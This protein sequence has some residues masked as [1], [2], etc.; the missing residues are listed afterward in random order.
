MPLS[1]KV[2]D[3]Q[4]RLAALGASVAD[5]RR[6]ENIAQLSQREG[7]AETSYSSIAT[8]AEQIESE[9]GELQADLANIRE[10]VNSPEIMADIRK[11]ADI[12]VA[13]LDH[14]KTLEEQINEA[15]AAGRQQTATEL[16]IERDIASE[17]LL[18]IAYAIDNEDWL[19]VHEQAR[20]LP[21]ELGFEE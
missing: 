7:A 6:R 3:I 15:K 18:K 1:Q 11:L 4:N 9:I 5:W 17:L 12:N 21:K 14:N 16:G 8:R 10:T 13:L 2:G 19:L 20:T